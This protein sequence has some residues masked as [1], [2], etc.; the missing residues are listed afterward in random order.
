M[1]K[2]AVSLI[3]IDKPEERASA[4]LH[5]FDDAKQLKTWGGPSVRF[6]LDLKQLSEMATDQTYLLTDQH[7]RVMGF[8]QF[9]VRLGR[10]HLSR[11]AIGPDYRGQGLGR[12]F[13]TLMMEQAVKSQK[14]VGHSLFVDPDNQTAIN[15]Y[16]SLG[17][18]FCPY[19]DPSE[20]KFDPYRYMVA[21]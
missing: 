2:D 8:G 12:K 3:R 17:F 20:Q 15:L 1:D 4:L 19:P 10:H 7:D 16:L 13:V 11:L 6:P 9:Y 18:V 5:W 21:V 14:A